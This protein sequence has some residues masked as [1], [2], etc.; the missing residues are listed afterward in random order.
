[1]VLPVVCG[2]GDKKLAKQM[3]ETRINERYLP[4]ITLHEDLQISNDLPACL[5]AADTI[6]FSLPSKVFRDVLH[7]LKDSIHP[8]QYLITTTKGIEPGS[9]LLMSQILEVYFPNNPIGVISGPQFC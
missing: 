6:L 8:A 9:F 1:M 4:G 5:M 2:Y 3:R 7:Q